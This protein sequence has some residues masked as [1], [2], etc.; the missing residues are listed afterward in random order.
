LAVLGLVM[1]AAAMA[2][3]RDTGARAAPQA[4]PA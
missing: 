2:L 3:P 1:L 4:V